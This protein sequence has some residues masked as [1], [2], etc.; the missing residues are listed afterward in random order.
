MVTFPNCK[1][2]L[3]LNILRKREDGFHDIETVF[4]PLPFYD[5]LEVVISNS[6]TQL[7]N[8]GI[9]GGDEEDNL[10][11]KA[12]HLLKKDFPEL[13]SIKIH[14]HKTIPVGAGL[15]GGSSDC[16][17]MLKLLN[18]KFDLKI[19]HEQLLVYASRL[20]SDCAFF[21]INSPCFAAG[22]GEK[23]MKI[24][25][26]LSS[27]KILLIHPG[28]HI[29]TKELFGKIT[30]AIPSKTL[31]E[32]IL[33]P[34]ESWKNDLKNDFEP[35]VFSMFPE[36][37]KLK[38]TLYNHKAVYASMTGTGSAV[39]GIFRSDENVDFQGNKKFFKKWLSL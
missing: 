9:S 29:S 20:G 17:F 18:E 39:F 15:G 36:I 30:P 35:I 24:N 10:C 19:S 33:Q 23:L 4:Y 2:N 25:L 12:Y 13:P 26:S 31:K 32:V 6:S 37:E 5:I 38:Q 3:G 34:I 16:A 21:L 11:L 28:I 22:V 7:I 27:Y 1:I 8:T 14:L